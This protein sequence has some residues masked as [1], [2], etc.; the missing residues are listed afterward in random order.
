MWFILPRNFQSASFLTQAD[1][2]WLTREHASSNNHQQSRQDR[3]SL[4][5]SRSSNPCRLL[6][7]AASNHRVWICSL[8]SF[9]KNAGYIGLLFWVPLIIHSILQGVD[10]KDGQALQP[11]GGHGH[12][13]LVESADAVIR[14]TP[15][16][17]Y[18]S[19]S[20]NTLPQIPGQQKGV[21]AALLTAIPYGAAVSAAVALGHSSQRLRDKCRHIAGP[22][23]IAALLLILFPY[24]MLLGKV[25]TF[26]CL[27]L[28]FAAL[29]APNP[30]LNSLASSVGFGPSLA[31]SL[32][33]YNAVGNLGGLVGPWLIGK[34]VQMT[35]LYAAALQVLGV[36]LG[37]AAG[38]CWWLHRQWRL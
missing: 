27:T 2:A 16:K 9:L 22:Y 20:T 23:S 38:L 29:T 25:A 36:I 12:R 14:K 11:S 4:E 21:T 1:K 5:P 17:G 32:A 10:V 18:G 24:I 7:L 15:I 31:L 35:E 37:L 33:L 30:V 13:N 19:N 3:E 26:V 34:V 6:Q 28:A 8:I